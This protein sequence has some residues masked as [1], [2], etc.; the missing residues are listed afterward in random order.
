MH[1]L[2]LDLPD[3]VYQP[4]VQKAQATGQTVEAVASDC[5]TDSVQQLTPGS[6]LRRWAGALDSGLSDLAAR[7][8]DYLGE[9]LRDELRSEQND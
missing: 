2:T 8:H 1:Q 7:H 4:L 5:L 3:E 6:R 9:A